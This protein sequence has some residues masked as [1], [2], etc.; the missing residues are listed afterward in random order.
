[1]VT[2]VERSTLILSIS[3]S[4]FTHT[5]GTLARAR[6]YCDHYDIDRLLW[7]HILSH[8]SAHSEY[9]GR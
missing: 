9:T 3:I 2:P 8:V 7:M 6:S 1:M 4:R 5:T